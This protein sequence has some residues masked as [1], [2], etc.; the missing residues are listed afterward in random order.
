MENLLQNSKKEEKKSRYIKA[1]KK[2]ADTARK[3]REA[4]EMCLL[5]LNLPAKGKLDSNLKELGLE[6]DDRSNMAALFARLFTIAISGD[7][8]AVEILMKYAGYDPEMLRKEK[9][10]AAK[11]EAL[12]NGIEARFGDSDDKED[13]DVVI[14][15][16]D[17][18]RDIITSGKIEEDKKNDGADFEAPFLSEGGETDGE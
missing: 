12:K 2:G 1:R 8:K 9:E 17:N 5:L 6:E 14:V 10:T 11:I 16:P 7:L 18:N 13:N 3:K 15:L 4:K